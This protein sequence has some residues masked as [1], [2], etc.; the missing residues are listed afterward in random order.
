MNCRVASVPCTAVANP[1]V[2]SMSIVIWSARRAGAVSATAGDGVDS[3]SGTRIR[4]TA[5]VTP[6]ITRAAAPPVSHITAGAGRRCPRITFL[7]I[8]PDRLYAV[9]VAAVTPDAP[10]T[11]RG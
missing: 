2:G 11:L 5:A 10:Y 7:P 6:P 1:D 9:R 8:D 3:G 4:P